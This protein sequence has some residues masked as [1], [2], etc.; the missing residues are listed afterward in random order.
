MRN[1][2]VYVL[3]KNT[4]VE[5]LVGGITS[6]ATRI[7]STSSSA[8]AIGWLLVLQM[9]TMDSDLESIACF[10]AAFALKEND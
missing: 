6:S 9:V 7:S 5:L 10:L 8:A 3:E 4:Y 2:K 1:I